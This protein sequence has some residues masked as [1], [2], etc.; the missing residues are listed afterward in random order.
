MIILLFCRCHAIFLMRA[1]HDIILLLYSCHRCQSKAMAFTPDAIIIMMARRRRAIYYVTAYVRDDDDASWRD[2]PPRDAIQSAN[3]CRAQPASAIL[4]LLIR[5]TRCVKEPAMPRG[6]LRS[7][8]Y[9]RRCG[10]KTARYAGAMPFSS[11]F[12]CH[13]FILLFF[14]I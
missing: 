1:L 7:Q 9:A 13:Y 4:F 6:A 12:S 2:T 8:R 10:A 5:E 14:F 11:F 3:Y